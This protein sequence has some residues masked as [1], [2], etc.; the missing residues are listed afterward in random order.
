MSACSLAWYRVGT[1]TVAASWSILFNSSAQICTSAI[2]STRRILLSWWRQSVA[3][4]AT[5][6]SAPLRNVP[7]QDHRK[8]ACACNL[9]NNLEFV[10]SCVCYC[11]YAWCNMTL[12]T[13]CFTHYAIQNLTVICFFLSQTLKHHVTSGA[14][15]YIFCIC[16]GIYVVA[17]KR[18]FN[19]NNREHSRLLALAYMYFVIFLQYWCRR[20]D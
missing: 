5:E 8:N 17:Y 4:K 9:S 11:L 13:W 12:L 2:S 1:N 14:R 18:I 7:I 10:Y 3:T 20:R 15:A 6:R 16:I 19:L